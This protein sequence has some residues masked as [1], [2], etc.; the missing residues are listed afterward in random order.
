MADWAPFAIARNSSPSN[1]PDLSSFYHLDKHTPT[2]RWGSSEW[3][4][5]ADWLT[6]VSA[7]VGKIQERK[8]TQGRGMKGDKR[9]GGEEMQEF[10]SA[11]LFYPWPCKRGFAYRL[12]LSVLRVILASVPAIR[13]FAKWVSGCRILLMVL[14]M[15]NDEVPLTDR[16]LWADVSGTVRHQQTVGWWLI[17]LLIESE[18]SLQS[19]PLHHFLL[20]RYSGELG[21]REWRESGTF[22][23]LYIVFRWWR[24]HLQTED[25]VSVSA[26]CLLKSWDISTAGTLNVFINLVRGLNSHYMC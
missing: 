26:V 11:L 5:E 3:E 25:D 6:A 15:L 17:T 18:G 16:P 8:I 13:F 20:Y 22:K 12:F 10:M 24:T 21:R 7:G 2:Y 1:E 23:L 19:N 4:S 9:R 14:I